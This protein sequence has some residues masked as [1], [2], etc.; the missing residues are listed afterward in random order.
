MAIERAF[1]SADLIDP[2]FAVVEARSSG[3]RHRGLTALI[4]GFNTGLLFIMTF[5]GQQVGLVLET[6]TGRRV[7]G[8]EEGVSG[9]QDVNKRQSRDVRTACWMLADSMELP[10]LFGCKPSRLKNEARSQ[11]RLKLSIKPMLCAVQDDL[12]QV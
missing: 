4:E 6:V 7:S 9:E 12:S 2:K 1:N 5:M 11:N 8:G 10:S 3:R